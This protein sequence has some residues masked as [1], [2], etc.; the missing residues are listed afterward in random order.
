MI[1]GRRLSHGVLLIVLLASFPP[2]ACSFVEAQSAHRSGLERAGRWFTYDGTPTYLVGLDT[3]Q[4]A[5]DPTIDIPATLDRLVQYRINK[6]RVW[7]YCWFMVEP[8]GLS[9]WKRVN[10]I[11]NLDEFDDVQYWP[12]MRTL[13]AEAQARN[14][15]V[16]V[17]LF[18]PYSNTTNY[19]WDN[20]DWQNAWNKAFNSN[21][22]FT[23]NTHGH[24]YPQFH[25]LNHAETSASGKTLRLYQQALVDKAM[26]ELSLY[27]NVYFEIANE[28]AVEDWGAPINAIHDPALRLWQETWLERAK[29]QTPALVG[30]HSDSD[31]R[32][33]GAE[34]WTRNSMIDVLNFRLSNA[35]PGEISAIL[36]ASGAQISGKVLTINE[37]ATA[38]I[39]ETLDVDP[40]TRAAWGMFM[41]GGTSAF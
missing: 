26:M 25:D 11:H 31:G 6:V 19:W 2:V 21:Q 4:L 7:L 29:L 23:S 8:P 39:D 3:Q 34:Y 32:G 5:A 18:A 35:S 1:K 24:F 20:P 14:I 33:K 13:M 22:A 28:F 17:T 12:R 10:G 40:H 9:P 38:S 16:E 27:D 30:V 37:T 41:A 15:I 36:S